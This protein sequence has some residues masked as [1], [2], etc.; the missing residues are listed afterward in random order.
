MRKLL[1]TL[2]LI[3]LNTFAHDLIEKAILES[4]LEAFTA[5]IENRKRMQRPLTPNEQLKYL[6]LSKE[7]VIRRR[8]QLELP[9]ENTAMKSDDQEISPLA[10][11]QGFFG[12]IG[13][14]GIPFAVFIELFAP[15]STYSSQKKAALLAGAAI[16]E[17]PFL[18]MVANYGKEV[19][20]KKKIR[21]AKYDNALKIRQILYDN[22]TIS[23]EII[24]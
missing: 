22:L 16:A 14:L 5:E 17:I 9:L 3:S 18:W 12:T 15:N 23:A 20:E 19:E 7:V 13:L 21:E 4:N 10:Y 8:D 2:S 6:D 11:L 24:R 1:F